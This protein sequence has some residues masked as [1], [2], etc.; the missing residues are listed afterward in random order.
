MMKKLTILASAAMLAP[1][2]VFGQTVA[3]APAP[4]SGFL[5][6]MLETLNGIITSL[7]PI[8]LGAAVLFFL[9]G[10]FKYVAAGDD[11][12]QRKSGRQLMI[13]GIIAIF[14]MVSLWGLVNMLD[15][16]FGLDDT[17][18]T[19]PPVEQFVPLP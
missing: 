8:V 2:M 9:W 3:S 13:N 10:V 7:V 14:V 6:D 17:Q 18:Q 11:E 5:N 4:D 19:A 1:M 15:N 12:E 16:F